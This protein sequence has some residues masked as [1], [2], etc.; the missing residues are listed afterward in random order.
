VLLLISIHLNQRASLRSVLISSDRLGFPTPHSDALQC[1]DEKEVVIDES[2]RFH[3]KVYFLENEW[4]TKMEN[5]NPPIINS[6][7]SENSGNEK[8]FSKTRNSGKLN[9]KVENEN[10]GD[11]MMRMFTRGI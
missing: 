10:G 2:G 7:H 6:N 11:P 3:T 9:G 5:D 8:S 1:E 4:K